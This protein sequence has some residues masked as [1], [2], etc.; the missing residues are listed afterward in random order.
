MRDLLLRCLDSLE[1]SIPPDWEIIVVVNAD[2]DGTAAATRV[3]FPRVRLIVNA[4]NRGVGRARNQGLAVA[5]G[6]VVVLLDAD[7]EALPGALE[8]LAATLMAEPDIGVVGPQLVSSSGDPQRTA[9]TFPTILTKVRRRAPTPLRRLLP[10]D[11]LADSAN[12]R[13]VGYVIGAC[14]A[15]RSVA[16][17]EVGNLDEGIFYGPED[18][19]LCL[20]MWKSGWRVVWDPTVTIMHHEQRATR[21]RLLSTLT[22][23]HGAGLARYFMKHRYLF[24]AP[25][26]GREPA[27]G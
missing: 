2:V 5:S 11:D 6:D 18:V 16:L 14:Q 4:R 26:F 19:D 23:R 9:R 25:A 3:R 27:A 8:A 15:I 13:E 24:R 20:R 10:S 7:T 22:L 12:P 21:R 17:E 1:A